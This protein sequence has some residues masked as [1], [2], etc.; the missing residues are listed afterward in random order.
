MNT[1]KYIV[2]PEGFVRGQ[3]VEGRASGAGYSIVGYVGSLQSD[4]PE[5][6]RRCR[7]RVRAKLDAAGVGNNWFATAA[8]AEAI[9]DG[10]G[11]K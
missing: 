3:P 1:T 4:P 7:Q 9:M 11:V 5:K 8:E 6:R 10:F 2:V